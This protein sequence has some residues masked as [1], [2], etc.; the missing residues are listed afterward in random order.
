MANRKDRSIASTSF[1]SFVEKHKGKTKK[2]S[3][4][5]L[6]ELREEYI[7]AIGE[8]DNFEYEAVPISLRNMVEWEDEDDNSDNDSDDNEDIDDEDDEDDEDERPRRKLRNSRK[9]RKVGNADILAAIVGLTNAIA[10][11][12]TPK[13]EQPEKPE[14][15]PETKKDLRDQ[16]AALKAEIAAQTAQT[17]T[18]QKP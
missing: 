17:A 15:K 10:G 6:D 12:T 4:E 8:N 11:K 18:P 5:K 2:I 9:S 14:P 3:V 16:V 7:D 13:P 1:V